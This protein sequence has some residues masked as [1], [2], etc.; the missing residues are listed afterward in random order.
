MG[1]PVAQVGAA[2]A[3]QSAVGTGAGANSHRAARRPRLRVLHPA[4]ARGDRSQLEP[5]PGGRQHGPLELHLAPAPGAVLRP[6]GV[7]PD[8]QQ[9]ERRARGR[10]VPAEGLGADAAAKEVSKHVVT[11]N[12]VA[13][14]YLLALIS[15][16]F[17]NKHICLSFTHLL[18]DFVKNLSSTIECSLC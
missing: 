12:A 8:V 6:P 15:F 1:A 9:Q 2:V 5:R 7:L 18:F 14:L 11:D 16:V 4:E 13:A 3:V 17:V 10:R